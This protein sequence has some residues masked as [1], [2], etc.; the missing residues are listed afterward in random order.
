MRYPKP[1]A[2]L[3]LSGR[4]VG[5]CVLH[6]RPVKHWQRPAGTPRKGFRAWV[7]DEEQPTRLYG[8]MCGFRVFKVS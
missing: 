2:S 3:S 6:H 7:K 4:G 8:A 5:R 1:S